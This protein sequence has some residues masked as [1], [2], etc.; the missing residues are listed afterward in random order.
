[1]NTLHNI[2]L[3]MTARLFNSALAV[4]ILLSCYATVSFA[5][6]PARVIAGWA[7]KVRVENHPYDIKA[8]LD[9]GAKTSSIHAIDIQP[10]KR[11]GERWAKFTLILN[12][13][14]G[15]QH[16]ITLEKPRSRKASIKNHDGN[17]DTRYV[18]DLEVCFNGRRFT[19]EFTL[20]DRSE[21]IYDIL[22]GRQ[23]LKEAAII[24]PDKTFLTLASCEA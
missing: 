19:T 12:D 9:T 20:A 10:F 4:L 22:L 2:N 7:E 23:F 14:Q 18:I 3:A 17:N 8:K 15:E 11:D 16:K 6:S 21:Y 24:D 13:S 5:K 1:M